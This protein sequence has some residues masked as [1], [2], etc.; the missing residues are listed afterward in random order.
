MTM[1]TYR[2]KQIKEGREEKLHISGQEEEK[3]WDEEDKVE[4]LANVRRSVNFNYNVI[5][6]YISVEI[7]FPDL[8]SE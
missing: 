2:R 4:I 8:L 1:G 3:Q 5:V 6:E 7:S